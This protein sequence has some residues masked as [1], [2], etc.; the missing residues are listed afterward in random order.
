MAYLIRRKEPVDA[1]VRRILIEQNR[2]ALALLADWKQNPRDNVHQARQ[3][4]KRIRALLR[5]LRPGVRYVYKV[6]NIFYR[7]LGRKLAYARDSEAVIDA[8]GLLEERVSGPLAQDSLRMLRKGLEQ[9]A[10]RE[11]DCGIHDLA[12]RIAE[13]CDALGQAGKRFRNLPL[14]QLRRKHLKRGAE[15]GMERC[16]AAFDLVARTRAEADFHAWRKEVKYAYHQTRLMQHMLPR[17]SA[18][19]GPKLGALADS[20]GHFHDLVILDELLRRQAD[21]LNVDVHLRSMRNTVRSAKAAYAGEAL[22]AG[23]L[24]FGRRMATSANVVNI[25]SR[26]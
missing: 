7:D 12:G 10:A 4:F 5:L 1:E 15:V 16:V 17:W 24:I 18:T 20:L 26:A 21:E 9:R 3:A 19:R 23:P 11:R 22:A 6:E 14:E 2:R 25:T 8:L 13:A